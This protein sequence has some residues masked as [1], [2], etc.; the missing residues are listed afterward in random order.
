M[1]GQIRM[2]GVG[3]NR[4]MTLLPLGQI[5]YSRNV[6]PLRGGVAGMSIR[7]ADIIEHWAECVEAEINVRG[8]NS[9]ATGVVF[10][11]DLIQL[12]RLAV[13]VPSVAARK[14]WL[15]LLLDE[16]FSFE[17]S[18]W[19]IRRAEEDYPSNQPWYS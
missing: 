12:E 6:P 14:T 7:V 5:V 10:A 13:Q 11:L 18:H 1:S 2:V 19:A 8:L 4:R 3:K 9:E 16:R 15:R 17:W